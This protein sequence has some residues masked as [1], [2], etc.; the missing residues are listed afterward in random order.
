MKTVKQ[1]SLIKGRSTAGDKLL[2]EKLKWRAKDGKS[3][4]G[5]DA[6]IL[7]DVLRTNPSDAWDWLEESSGNLNLRNAYGGSKRKKGQR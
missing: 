5:L 6:A 3:Y 1:E 7:L 4:M 2:E